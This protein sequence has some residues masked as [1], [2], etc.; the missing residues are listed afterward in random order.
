MS[1][2]DPASVPGAISLLQRHRC[3]SVSLTSP[4]I[5]LWTTSW[6]H[7]AIEKSNP[8]L[9]VT[10]TLLYAAMLTAPA[11]NALY[12]AF[13]QCTALLATYIATHSKT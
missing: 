9:F 11:A 10:C 1:V 8:K 12:N 13:T 3:W 5:H 4:I 7:R 6:L 2:S